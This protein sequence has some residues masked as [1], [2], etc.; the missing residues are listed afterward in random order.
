M[1]SS[2]SI[3][4]S[5]EPLR[6]HQLQ[7]SRCAA[8]YVS[9]AFAMNAA[10][11]ALTAMSDD[12]LEELSRIACAGGPC[13]QLDG[14]GW[15]TPT[16]QMPTSRN[17]RAKGCPVIPR[18]RTASATAPRCVVGTPAY[19]QYEDAP[20]PCDAPHLTPCADPPGI[21]VGKIHERGSMIS[22]LQSVELDLD[23]LFVATRWGPQEASRGMGF[24]DHDVA[25]PPI[26]GDGLLRRTRCDP[27]VCRLV[28]TAW[29]AAL[30]SGLSGCEIGR[31][32]PSDRAPRPTICVLWP[33]SRISYVSRPSIRKTTGRATGRL[34]PA[35]NGIP[36]TSEE[37]G[38]ARTTPSP[39]PSAP[40]TDGPRPR[41]PTA[42][43]NARHRSSGVPQPCCR[44]P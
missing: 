39:K 19:A 7:K 20:P 5:P 38:P 25:H 30:L 32:V 31:R 29:V 8:L 13:C 26:L 2:S 3:P 34:V 14:V 42:P 12:C 23:G 22:V 37:E 43:T 36:R 10:A 24:R 18:G 21:G 11:A 35:R 40:P 16:A 41:N 9:A 4:R 33:S 17:T 1:I 6:Y 27:S 44:G 28:R 15:R